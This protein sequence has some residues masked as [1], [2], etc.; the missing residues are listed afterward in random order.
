MET[1]MV[2]G[3]RGWDWEREDKDSDHGSGSSDFGERI[4]KIEVGENRETD[5]ER[6]LPREG[7]DD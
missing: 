1:V 7:D 5:R 3:K 6:P 4:N 2:D